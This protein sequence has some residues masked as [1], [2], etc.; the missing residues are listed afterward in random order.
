MLCLGVCVLQTVLILM[1][2]VRLKYLLFQWLLIY[3]HICICNQ[4][5]FRVDNYAGG[6][7]IRPVLTISQKKKYINEVHVSR[8][9]HTSLVN[10]PHKGTNYKFWYMKLCIFVAIVEMNLHFE[11]IIKGVLHLPHQILHVLCSISK[12]STISWKIINASYSK[13]PKEL[14]NGIKSSVGQAIFKLWI[15]T[16]KMLFGSIT[17]ELLGLLKFWCYFWVPWTIY[18]CV[19]VMNVR[20]F[21]KKK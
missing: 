18:N 15:N 12:L 5:M 7:P 10:I 14:K 13:L 9:Y 3:K 2:N 11:M 6:K 20:P 4:N 16:F 21:C 17:Q 8:I 1:L 19:I